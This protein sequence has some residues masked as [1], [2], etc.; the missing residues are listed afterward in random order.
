MTGTHPPPKAGERLAVAAGSAL[1]LRLLFFRQ[2]ELIFPFTGGSNGVFLDEAWRVLAGEVMYRDFFEFLMPGT[3]YLYAAVFALLGPTTR[4]LGWALLVQGALLA[5]LMHALASRLAGPGWRLLPPAAFVALVHAPG[6]LGDHKWP[7]LA[8]GMLGLLVL[9]GGAASFSRALA[10]GLLLGAS[11]AFTQ[12]LGL[13]IAAGALA[14][15]TLRRPGTPALLALAGGCALVPLLVVAVFAHFA[16]LAAILYDCVVFPLTR[17]REFNVF[18]FGLGASLR[19]LPRE[20]AQLALA[21]AGL[22]GAFVALRRERTS[23]AGLLAGAGLGMMLATAHRGLF[24]VALAMQSS[25]LL[26][27]AARSFATATRARASGW[28]HAATLGLVGLGL[29][30]GSF[31]MVVWRQRLQPL[32]LEAHRA[33]SVWVGTPMP[34]LAWVERHASPGEP[35]FLLPARGGHYFLTRSRNATAF[36]YLIEGQSAPEQAVAALAQ[37][38]RTPPRVGLW[39]VRPGG[40]APPAAHALTPLREGLLRDYRAERFPNGVLALHRRDEASARRGGTSAPGEPASRDERV[41]VIGQEAEPAPRVVEQPELAPQ[42]DAARHALAPTMVF[43]P[44]QHRGF[45]EDA[46]RTGEQLSRQRRAGIAARL[47]QQAEELAQGAVE[48]P[49]RAPAARPADGRLQALGARLEHQPQVKVADQRHAE[50]V[51]RQRERVI[52][53]GVGVLEA[54]GVVRPV[55]AHPARPQAIVVDPVARALD[56]AVMDLNDHLTQEQHAF[57]IGGHTRGG[58]ARSERAQAPVEQ[59]PADRVDALAGDEHVDVLHRTLPGMGVQAAPIVGA[60]QQDDG[61]ALETAEQLGQGILEQLG[62]P[63]VEPLESAVPLQC[64][65]HDFGQALLREQQRQQALALGLPDQTR[66]SGRARRGPCLPR[67]QLLQQGPEGRGQA[68]VH[69][70]DQST[71]CCPRRACV[72]RAQWSVTAFASRR[73]HSDARRWTMPGAKRSASHSTTRVRH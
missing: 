66:R 23:V 58:A 7:A 44:G 45:E 19:T 46:C 10:A 4:A 52:G 40:A 38:A 36:P 17:Y 21:A 57:V 42:L 49:D 6:T 35:V 64:P 62:A 53:Q 72:R 29:L 14:G 20:L 41:G 55:D 5:L 25:L 43:D 51:D 68:R 34:E 70:R 63:E 50:L 67:G 16:G 18:N 28:L 31:G 48:G 54:E 33:G 47:G 71:P 8:A 27:L 11:M 73:I 69:E 3:T 56:E 26:P 22:W 2:G 15:L 30:H 39:D 1:L 65:A 12:D 24:P 61:L 60:L 32:T 9:T 37:I 13:G 59:P